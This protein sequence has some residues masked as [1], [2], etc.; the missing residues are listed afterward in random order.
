[1]AFAQPVPAENWMLKEFL[2]LREK[3]PRESRNNKNVRP[4]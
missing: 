2:V 3:F 1:M 4:G